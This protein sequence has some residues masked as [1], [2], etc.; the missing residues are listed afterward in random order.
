[1]V[2][3]ADRNAK[4]VF[5]EAVEDGSLCLMGE[6]HITIL[7]FKVFDLIFAKATRSAKVKIPDVFIAKDA[8]FDLGPLPPIHCL[9]GVFFG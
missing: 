9:V 6:D 8:V 7:I 4:K 3:S 2:R 5:E 1:V